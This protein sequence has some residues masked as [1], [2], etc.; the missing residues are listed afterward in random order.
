MRSGVNFCFALHLK[1]FEKPIIIE[2]SLH[3]SKIDKN[4]K[5]HL[6]S[7]QDTMRLGRTI[8]S[9]LCGGDVIGM[10]GELGA[11]KTTLSR[12]IAMGLGIME[13]LTSPTYTLVNEY[14]GMLPLY[15]F[16]LYRL[17]SLRDIEGIGIEEYFDNRNVIIIEWVD[18]LDSRWLKE[19]LQINLGYQELDA[20]S[21]KR[22]AELIPFG[23][24]YEA[25]VKEIVQKYE[26]S[27]H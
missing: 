17:E 25:L 10:V 24:R 4:M 21:K 16:D 13:P 5:I 15:H 18:K 22:V 19:Y 14:Q 2:K 9:L 8:G 26:A 20:V 23:P 1:L 7:V 12:F 27:R 3:S 6:E 11:G